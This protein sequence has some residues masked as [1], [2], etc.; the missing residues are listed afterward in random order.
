M[1]NLL[2]NGANIQAGMAHMETPADGRRRRVALDAD[3]EVNVQ[4]LID[5]RGEV[6]RVI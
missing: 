2:F 1:C 6:K 4:V 5:K 3:I